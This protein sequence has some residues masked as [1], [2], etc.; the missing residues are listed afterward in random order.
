MVS[1]VQR[2]AA[3]LR[4][5]PRQQAVSRDAAG[6]LHGRQV[7]PPRRRFGFL[8]LADP[9]VAS[10]ESRRSACGSSPDACSGSTRRRRPLLERRRTRQQRRRQGSSTSST[11]TSTGA[12]AATGRLP[13]TDGERTCALP[14]STKK[15]SDIGTKSDLTNR[16]HMSAVSIGGHS[17]SSRP[18]VKRGRGEVQVDYLGGGKLVR[19]RRCHRRLSSVGRDM[20]WLVGLRWPTRQ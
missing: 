3:Y 18:S 15:F 16:A 8:L 20:G 4:C 9:H 6:L 2:R 11:P 12:P 5:Q 14:N 1:S 10:Q 13:C 19:R 7:K 17:P